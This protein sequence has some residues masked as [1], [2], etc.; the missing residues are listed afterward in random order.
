MRL[1]RRLHLMIYLYLQD[2]VNIFSDIFLMNLLRRFF[3][4]LY[5][6]KIG[7]GCIFN[8]K[9][10]FEVPEKIEIGDHCAFN[11]GCWISGGGG[12]ILHNDVIIGPNVIIHTANHNYGNP[13]LSFRMQGHT[14]EKVEIQDNVWIGAGA[15]ILPGVTIHANSIVAAGAVV[16]K[17]V[18]SNSI[19]GG[20][21]ARIIKTIYE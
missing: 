14:Y 20:V 5:F 1:S 6:K 3:Y 17:D 4:R 12:L 9:C 13:K 19:V 11:R 21:P 18:S 2:C 8:C 15:I 16:T 7:K 10:H